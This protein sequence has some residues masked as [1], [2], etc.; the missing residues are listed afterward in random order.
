M[1][2]Q[3]IPPTFGSQPQQTLG[4]QPQPGF[5]PQPP[6]T[7]PAKKGFMTSKPVIGVA[8]LI[9]GLT[10]GN[11]MGA[12]RTASGEPAP[13]STVTVTATAAATDQP[14]E[15][16]TDE[17]TEEPSDEP[18]EQPTEKPAD[19]SYKYGQKVGFTYSDVEITVRVDAPKT[20]TNMFDKDNLEAK[21][22]VCNRG[23]ETVDELSAEGMGLY[24]ED[25]K[26][27]VYDLMGAYRTPEF[28]VYDWD[29]ATL[30]AG[31]CRTGWVQFEDAKKAVRI[32]TEVSET[33]YS[34]SKSGK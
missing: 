29:S 21:V 17:A 28:P 30:K 15:E 34:W 18:T 10:L 33:T 32:A 1:T 31:K 4:S 8:A 13:A 16:P 9:V 7:P 27:G 3:Q 19:T 24:A 23:K 14:S 26:G 25:A 12:S 6:P 20:S 2:N 5:Q 22:T 11:S